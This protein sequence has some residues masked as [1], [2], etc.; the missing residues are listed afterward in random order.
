MN[1]PMN[2]S[3]YIAPSLNF[4]C[5]TSG[6]DYTHILKDCFLMYMCLLQF[7]IVALCNRHVPVLENYNRYLM[8]IIIHLLSLLTSHT[9]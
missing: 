2:S 4:Y 7:Q 1:V 8:T 9:G 3:I 6:K 5:I